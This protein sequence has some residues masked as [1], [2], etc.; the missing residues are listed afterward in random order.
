MKKDSLLFYVIMAVAGL[1]AVASILTLNPVVICLASA[2]ILVSVV[3]YKLWYVIDSLIFKRTNL[4]EL[5]NG[6]ELSKDRN[7]AIRRMDDR[8]SSTT[9]AILNV[10]KEASIDRVDI[11]N[12]IAHISYP[13]KFVM[14]VEKLNVG[15]IMEGLQTSRSIKEIELSRLDTARSSVRINQL[16][17]E[18]ELIHHD[19]NAI[20]TGET[21]VKL[22]HYIFTTAVSDTFYDAEERA[23]S[24]IR[25][26]SSQ[27]DALL[28]SKSRIM[29]GN[30]LLDLLKVDSEMVME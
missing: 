22:A 19:I 7:S 4:I 17:R 3:I 18:L 8:V 29:D 14:Q 23:K 10:D 20:K 21:P 5:F 6:Y 15:K 28:K 13:F 24:Q 16:K 2:S 30:E 25:E 26:L 9:A 27:F 1:L 11:E 12:I